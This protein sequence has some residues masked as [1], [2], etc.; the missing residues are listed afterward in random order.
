MDSMVREECDYIPFFC[1]ENVW[2][3][4]KN[5]IGHGS[6]QEDSCAALF[7][8]G[9]RGRVAVFDQRAGRDG[10]GLALW[11]YHVAAISRPRDGVPLVYD[12]DSRSGF[13]Q[14]ATL[15]IEKSFG[16]LRGLK[17]LIRPRLGEILS[18]VFTLIPAGPFVTRFHSDR[19]HMLKSDGSWEAEPPPWAPPD[20]SGLGV[21]GDEWDLRRLVAPHQ[22]RED[23]RIGTLLDL[24]GLVGYLEG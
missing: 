14:S 15:W 7:I 4:L 24:Q 13:A 23:G 5:G 12:F 1:E 2:R 10:D 18:P 9:R 16:P 17:S 19:S 8:L 20:G 6:L 21:A 11:D 3:L 22:G